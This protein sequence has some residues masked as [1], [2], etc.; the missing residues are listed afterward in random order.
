MLRRV[1]ASIQGARPARVFL[2]VDAARGPADIDNVRECRSVSTNIGW[3]CEV[4]TLFHEAHMGCRKGVAT[5]IDW[6]F[7]QIEEGIILEDDCVPHAS[8]FSFAAELLDRYR[9]DERVA[10][11]S[12]DCFLGLDRLSPKGRE[13]ESYYFSRFTH[14]WGWASWRRAWKLYDVNMRQWPQIK[15]GGLT[16]FIPDSPRPE[17]WVERLENTFSGLI[18]TWDWQWQFACWINRVLTINPTLN[19]VSNI[20]FGEHATHS[21]NPDDP[22]SAIPVQKMPLPLIHPARVARDVGVDGWIER[23]IYRMGN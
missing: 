14:V 6:F 9:H 11:I 2:A 16:Q 19:L 15:A 5:A 7:S 17:L 3:P 23:F 10:H 4:N 21:I 1:M 8:F 13:G 12:G 22:K 18:D 20:G